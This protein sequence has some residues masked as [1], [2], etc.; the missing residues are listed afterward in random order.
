MAVD[1]KKEDKQCLFKE[2]IVDCK[3]E[4]DFGRDCIEYRSPQTREIQ[5][6]SLASP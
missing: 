5:F 6:Q 2:E 4:L 3:E 1:D